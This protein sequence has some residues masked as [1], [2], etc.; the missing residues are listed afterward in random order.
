MSKTQ[1]PHGYWWPV[2]VIVTAWFLACS[3]PSAR[4]GPRTVRPGESIRLA[5]DDFLLVTPRTNPAHL[6]GQLDEVVSRGA[7]RIIFLNTGESPVFSLDSYRDLHAPV[8]KQFRAIDFVDWYPDAGSMTTLSEWCVDERLD[9]IVFVGSV[10]PTSKLTELDERCG[11]HLKRMTL[12]FKRAD[13]SGLLAFIKDQR[14]LPDLLYIRGEPGSPWFS[15]DAVRTAVQRRRRRHRPDSLIL[16]PDV[17]LN[18]TTD[19]Q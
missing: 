3:T 6:K 18:A 9:E 15:A 4:R 1:F 17:A 14:R 8:G 19:S 10:F 5:W 12:D 16:H 13:Q 7:S 2:A 11:E